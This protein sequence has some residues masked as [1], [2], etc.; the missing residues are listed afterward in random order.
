MK[1]RYLITAALLV[2][3]SF[4]FSSC[5]KELDIDQHGVSAYSKFYITDS[6]ADEANTAIYVKWR[7]VTHETQQFLNWLSDDFWCGGETHWNSSTAYPTSDFTYGSDNS[8]LSGCYQKIFNTVYACNVLLTNIQANIA[9]G[10]ATDSEIKERAMAEARVMRALCYFELTALWGTPPLVDHPLAAS[11]YSQP[12]AKTAD[13]WAFV[14]N[15]LTTAINSGHLTEKASVN[16]VTY[17]LTKQYAQALLGK[18]YL[19]QKK[20]AAALEQFN[21][22]INSGKYDL[23]ADYENLMTHLADGCC[24]S[25]FEVNVPYDATNKEAVNGAT[26]L[27]AC[28]G[29]TSSHWSIPAGLDLAAKG[30]GFFNPTG[31]LY[32]EFVNDNGVDGYRLNCVIKT[33]PQMKSL[34]NI[35]LSKGVVYDSEGYIDHKFRYLASEIQP[36]ASWGV[37]SCKN[38]R[39]MRYAD[40]YLMAAECALQTGEVNTATNYVNKVRTRAKSP[41]YNTVTMDQIKKERRLELFG[42]MVRFMDLVRWGDAAT[43]LKEKGTVSP[44]YYY[45]YET[46]TSTIKWNSINSIANCGFKVGKHE[47][48]PFPAKEISSN[49]NM[50]QNPGW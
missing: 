1:L 22:V 43:V 39:W 16:D 35:T 49:P 18:T 17:R 21:L 33:T 44:D 14:E 45:N 6:D 38:V 30:W 7:T 37:Q 42:E 48:L 23:Y 28:F 10:K 9:A 41:L 25:L 11:E 15:D 13:L 20:Y 40:V 50:K 2:G 46:S 34:Y 27:W 5:N 24:E 36:T 31:S 19:Y 4:V 29:I 3:A 8:V 32:Q 26:H 12:N 47:L